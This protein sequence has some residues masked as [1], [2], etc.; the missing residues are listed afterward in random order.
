MIGSHTG[1]G[2]QG[3]RRVRCRWVERRGRPAARPGRGG[4]PRVEGCRLDPPFA[5]PMTG[6]YARIGRAQDVSESVVYWRPNRSRQ[7][8]A[9]VVRAAHPTEARRLLSDPWHDEGSLAFSYWRPGLAVACS[10]GARRLISSPHRTPRQQSK[11]VAPTLTHVGLRREVLAEAAVGQARGLH[12]VVL[13]DP[14]TRFIPQL[15]KWMVV[16]EKDDSHVLLRTPLRPVTVRH[17]LS[18]TSGLTGSSELQRVTGSDSTPLK[19]RA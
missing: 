6:S 16:E 1:G 18:H 8:A 14:V 4:G 2:L 12:Q 9:R 10:R 5:R 19:A 3:A 13:D 17:V 15:N 7:G 11:W